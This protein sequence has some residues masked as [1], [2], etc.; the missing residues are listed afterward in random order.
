MV[1][2]VAIA[3]RR[4]L[5]GVLRG[6]KSWLVADRHWCDL[7]YSAAMLA[8]MV[9]LVVSYHRWPWVFTWMNPIYLLPAVLPL[10]RLFLLGL[11]A[12][13]RWSPRLV[14]AW[15]VAMV[16]AS[17]VDLGVVLYHLS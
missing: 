17:I 1:A 15:M 6:A 16:S 13:W 8:A 11:G 5:S 2:G 4:T 12:L 9:A 7:V 3:L 14:A 10:Y